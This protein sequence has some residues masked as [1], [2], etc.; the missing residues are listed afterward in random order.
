MELALNATAVGRVYVSVDYDRN[1]AVIITARGCDRGHSYD[2][3]EAI[4]ERKFP[5]QLR[6]LLYLMF[7][8]I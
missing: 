8:I 2:S 4:V 1:V 5:P 7:S 3:S 6:N